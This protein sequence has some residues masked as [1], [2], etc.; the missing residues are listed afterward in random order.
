LDW[1]GHARVCVCARASANPPQGRARPPHGSF[2]HSV[3]LHSPPPTT[4]HHPAPAHRHCGITAPAYPTTNEYK[5]LMNGKWDI[6]VLML[7]TNDAKM[8]KG[9]LGYF[10][11]CTGGYDTTCTD[12]KVGAPSAP[13]SRA[14]AAWC[15]LFRSCPPQQ[16]PARA[17]AFL[18]P[19]L[20][21][22]P[23]SNLPSS[24]SDTTLPNS[25]FALSLSLARS[26]SP[27]AG[28]RPMP[29]ATNHELRHTPLNGLQVPV[30]CQVPP[31][32]KLRPHQQL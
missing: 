7:G 26:L 21:A 30:L 9:N 25:T 27:A 29:S 11:N 8:G 4:T 20:A 31:P 28:T 17:V 18:L 16:P 15:A 2:S 22:S 10:P 24:L 14:T 32:T 1:T 3:P 19:S 23:P 5:A 12:P 6:I 13:H